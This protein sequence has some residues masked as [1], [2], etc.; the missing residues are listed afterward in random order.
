MQ[1]IGIFFS[2]FEG[3]FLGV[4][5]FFCN[6]AAMRKQA[7]Y[8]QVAGLTFGVQF[9]EGLELE[10]KLQAYEPFETGLAE[11]PLFLLSFERVEDGLQVVDWKKLISSDESGS[12]V[13]IY[14]DSDNGYHYVDRLISKPDMWLCIDFTREMRGAHCRFCG[15][16]S[17]QLYALNNALMLM[18]ALCSAPKDALLFHSSV[19]IFEGKGY[20][21]LGKSGTGKSTHSKLWL[22]YIAG[23]ELLNDDNPVVRIINGKPWV[24]GSPWSGKTP[25]YQ[26]KSVPVGGFVRLWQAPVNEIKRLDILQAYAALLPTVSSMRWEAWCA[27]PINATLNRLIQ[28]VPVFSLRN[29]PEEAAALMSFNALT[30]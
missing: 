8:Y 28:A 26:N 3:F 29:R 1:V 7:K 15:D 9:G 25:C 5:H 18:F 11:E 30:H 22:N 10:G 24:F 16:A 13:E 12:M 19:V 17:F 4:E 14:V 20:M 2:L 21:F 27:D 6:F 23:S